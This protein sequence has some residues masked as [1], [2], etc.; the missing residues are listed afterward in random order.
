MTR[1][2]IYFLIN[3]LGAGGAERVV[4]NIAT[5]FSWSHNVTIITLKDEKFFDLPE[6]VKYLPLSH[7]RNNLVMVMLIPWF[8]FRLRSLLPEYDTGV[9]FLE[10]SNF[11]H[12]L[13]RRNAIISFRIHIDFFRGFVGSV[14]RLLI[15]LLYPKAGKII[16]NSEEN[17]YDLADFLYIPINRITTIYNPISVAEIE[18]KKQEPVESWILERIK[19]KKVFVTT[20]RLEWQKHHELIIQ[21]FQKLYLLGERDF[22]WLIVGDWWERNRLEKMV[23][24][25][26][27]QGNV[28][29]LGTQKN[30]FKYLSIAHYF[31]YAS[32]IEWFPNVLIEAMACNLPII[33]SDFKSGA[34]ECVLW[35]YDKNT[36][37]SME[38]P[39]YWPNGVVLWP[40]TFVDNFIEVYKDIIQIRQNKWGFERFETSI[41]SQEWLKLFK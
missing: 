10:I 24:D 1:K 23:A 31:V 8:Y 30:V 39:Y 3:S 20:G 29:F 37:K 38:Y 7:T 18:Q 35:S 41:V 2:K 4:S 32:E 14:Y 17:R 19:D 22:I 27:L 26:S 40:N 34:K 11:L 21:A 6:N 12:I 5:D 28:L 13:A 9:S 33:T 36:C 16:V 15:K 25:S